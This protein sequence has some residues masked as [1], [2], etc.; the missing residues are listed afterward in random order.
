MQGG[1]LDRSG[2]ARIRKKGK[3][4][5]E[6][7]EERRE[8]GGKNGGKRREKKKYKMD[9]KGEFKKGNHRACAK[10]GQEHANPQI[11]SS[12]YFCRLC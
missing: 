7:R 1:A 9:K 10:A 5:E 11:S 4:G 8:E 6:R 3:E 2:L 12:S